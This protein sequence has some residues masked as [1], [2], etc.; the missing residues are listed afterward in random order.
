LRGLPMIEAEEKMVKEAI[1]RGRPLGGR[2]G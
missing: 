2:D 1:E